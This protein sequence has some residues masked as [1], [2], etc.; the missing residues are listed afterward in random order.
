MK[1]KKNKKNQYKSSITKNHKITRK[2]NFDGVPLQAYVA[3]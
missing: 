3:S 1:K 2:K